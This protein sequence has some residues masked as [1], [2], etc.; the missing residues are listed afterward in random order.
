MQLS[1][2][3]SLSLEIIAPRNKWILAYLKTFLRVYGDKERTAEGSLLLLFLNEVS[4]VLCLVGRHSLT[5]QVCLGELD[6]CPSPCAVLE[7]PGL[8]VSH[9]LPLLR[10]CGFPPGQCVSECARRSMEML[11]LLLRA[12]SW[13]RGELQ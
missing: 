11:L 3:R 9:Y 13:S 7:V 1:C 2:E 5:F 10:H 6:S 8:S 4:Q 12:G